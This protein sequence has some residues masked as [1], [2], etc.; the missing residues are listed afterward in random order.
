MNNRG[1]T[2]IEAIVSLAIFIVIASTLAEIVIVS[3]QNQI[4]VSTMQNMFNQAVFALDKVEKEL[5][6]AKKD[7]LGTCIGAE[8]NYY[9]E[10][11]ASITFLYNDQE[12]ESGPICKKFVLENN[13]MVEYVS[14]DG[15]I[16]NLSVTGTNITSSSISLDSLKFIVPN[17]VPGDLLQ[18]KVT[19]VMSLSS[20][21]LED[22][23]PLQFQT[24]ISERR[25]DL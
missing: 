24:T 7:S 5:R 6:M 20:S 2:L 19:I 13:Q 12:N 25:L 17:D 3:I 21:G 15:T 18:P 9:V 23:E 11:E 8:K 22:Q 16:A 10:G 1:F 4:K 14:T